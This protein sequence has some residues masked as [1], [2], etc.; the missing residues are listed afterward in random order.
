MWIVESPLSYFQKFCINIVKAGR[1]PRHVAF[2]MDGN[3]RYATKSNMRKVEG[4]VKGF[5]KLSQTLQWCFEL[6]IQEVTV[7]AFSIE[8]FKRSKEE[9]DYLME[10]AKEKFRKLHDEKNKIMELGV[11]IRVIGNLDLLP[12]DTR[13]LI[14]E[15]VIMTK[16]NNKLFLNIAFAY[17]SRDELTT[18]VKNILKGV[19]LGLINPDDINEKLI[20]QCLYTN[21]SRDPDLLVRTSG[22]VRF[23]DFLLWQIWNTNVCFAEVL[24]PDFCLWHLLASVFQYQRCYADIQKY[25]PTQKIEQSTKVKKFLQYLDEKR[26]AQIEMYAKT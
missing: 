22:E 5:D 17:T 25:Q 23:S 3:R 6:G 18:A 16:D 26:S 8:N 2:I 20:S 11:C 12:E 13:K 24:W 9:V 10:L 21:H 4:H 15:A 1:V 19:E 14:A 7:Y